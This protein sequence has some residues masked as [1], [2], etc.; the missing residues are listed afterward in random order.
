MGVTFEIQAR[1]AKEDSGNT[2]VS[3]AE[4]QLRRGY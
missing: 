4:L 2:V 1:K 3:P